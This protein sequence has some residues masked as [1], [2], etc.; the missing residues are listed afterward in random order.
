MA[1]STGEQRRL[2]YGLLVLATILFTLGFVVV[3]LF[4]YG[5]LS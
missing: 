4:A 2:L 3:W 5:P 1:D